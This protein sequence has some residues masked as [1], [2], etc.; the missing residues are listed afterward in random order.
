M[1]KSIA[2]FVECAANQKP[3]NVGLELL[4]EVKRQQRALS[5]PPELLAFVLGKRTEALDAV[6]GEYGADSVVYVCASQPEDEPACENITG[7]EADHAVE[8]LTGILKQRNPQL[9]LVGSTVLGRELAPRLAVRLSAAFL[10]D[11]SSMTMEE[12]RGVLFERVSFS[13][14]FIA[15]EL[16]P[17]ERMQIITVRQGIFPKLSPEDRSDGKPGISIRN[18]EKRSGGRKVFSTRLL[19]TIQPAADH[20]VSLE[21][22]DVIV[23]GGRGC[24]GER[25]FRLLKELA[26]LLGGVVGASRVAV[27]KG[28][29][30]HSHLVGQSGKI[31]AP[32]LY[33]NCGISGSIQHIVGM[34]DSQCVVSINTDPRALIFDVSD[35][36]V[37]GDLFIVLPV[38]IE[39]IR[40]LK[41]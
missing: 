23:A 14:S 19:E 6:L 11:C 31:V 15:T 34:R 20:I 18:I 3:K 35:Y 5:N 40:K 27:D 24:Q 4:S 32:K 37:V 2:V 17:E 12:K 33:I 10:S 29:I 36:G 26:E 38:L 16:V 28:W 22:A 1:G 21:D 25:G 30:D 7:T 8:A 41:G 13:G 39:E 9:L